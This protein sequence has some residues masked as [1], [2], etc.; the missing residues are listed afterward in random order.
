MPTEQL[1]EKKNESEL[2]SHRQKT[3]NPSDDLVMITNLLKELEK[4]NI[5]ENSILEILKV[6]KTTDFME[7]MIE[8]SIEDAYKSI[9]KELRKKIEL[10]QKKVIR[11]SLSLVNL[12]L[13]KEALLNY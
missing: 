7:R 8:A 2:Y 9:E 5:E 3:D 10:I 4:I 13:E 11:L 12:E 1:S 6:V